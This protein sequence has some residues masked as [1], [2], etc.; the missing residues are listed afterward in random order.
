MTAENILLERRIFNL[1]HV[2]K[3]EELVPG[4]VVQEGARDPTE[5]FEHFYLNYFFFGKIGG[6]WQTMYKLPPPVSRV[7][8]TWRVENA[9]AAKQLTMKYGS[10]LML[11]YD[12][13]YSAQVMLRAFKD[14]GKL[15]QVFTSRAIED[16]PEFW[17][18]VAPRL[19]KKY[20]TIDPIELVKLFALR[21]SPFI[22]VFPTGEIGL[23][24]NNYPGARQVLADSRRSL[25]VSRVARAK[26]YAT[27]PSFFR[28]TPEQM[29]AF[30]GQVEEF[31][32]HGFIKHYPELI[33]PEARKWSDAKAAFVAETLL[34]EQ[35]MDIECL[36]TVKNFEV[37]T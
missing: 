1:G 24:R 9:L 7:V 16:S 35:D 3:R 28:Y 30:L 32:Y 15:P 18:T 23:E 6:R 29:M 13:S 34:A 5:Q 27:I 10:D 4:I 17:Q 21:E 8:R 37:T 20:D 26:N 25:I 11:Y 31:N 2:P 36:H 22:M 33:I 19:S 14:A 12:G